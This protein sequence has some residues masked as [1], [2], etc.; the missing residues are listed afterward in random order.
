VERLAPDPA[1]VATKATSL[2]S[3][4]ELELKQILAQ[5]ENALDALLPKFESRLANVDQIQ[6]WE[7]ATQWYIATRVL[8]EGLGLDCSREPVPFFR[9]DPYLGIDRVWRATAR[10]FDTPRLFRSDML[11][12]YSNDLKQQLRS[13]P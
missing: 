2:R 3:W 7:S 5:K 6:S 9:K 1:L 12:S 10:D 13:R 8:S 11:K 4:L